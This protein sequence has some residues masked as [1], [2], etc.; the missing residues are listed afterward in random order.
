MASEIVTWRRILLDF[1]LFSCFVVMAALL[2]QGCAHEPHPN[3][4]K[5]DMAATL[6]RRCVSMY[7]P[8][9]EAMCRADSRVY[10]LAAGIEADCAHQEAW[11]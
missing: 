4:L 7:G 10:C 5:R 11:P 3:A 6:Y 8:F 2:F 9:D 1:V